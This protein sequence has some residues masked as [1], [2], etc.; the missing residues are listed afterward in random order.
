MAPCSIADAGDILD[1]MISLT[2]PTPL[3]RVITAGDESMALYLALRHRGF[4][5][6]ATTATCRLPRG[7]HTVGLIAGQNPIGEIEAISPFLAPKA[8]LALLVGAGGDG[9]KI[10]S[11][12]ELI[13]FRI[14]AGVR[15]KAGLVLSAHRQGYV[16]LQKAA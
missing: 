6:V 5:R 2:H 8:R 13:G 12:L 16:Q 9:L 4:F 7:Q 14:E 10:R 3:H 15:C 1:T 11:K